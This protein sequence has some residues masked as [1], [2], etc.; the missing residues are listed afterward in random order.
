M[1]RLRRDDGFTLIE[2]LVSVSIG[3]VVLLGAFTL[4]DQAMPANNRIA[5]R[6]T[7]QARGRTAT[8]QVLAELHSVICVAQT[9][10]GVTTYQT[11]FDAVSN[12]TQVTFYTQMLGA[13]TGP[14]SPDPAIVNT[15]APEKRILHVTGGQLVEQRY[16]GVAG[17][18]PVGS[19]WT[20]PTL[21]SSRVVLPDVQAYDASTKYFTYYA[22]D[23][24]TL[25][26]PLSSADWPRVA[27]VQIAFKAG[28]NRTG[29]DPNAFAQLKDSA[30]VP[31]PVDYTDATTTAKGPQ[32]AY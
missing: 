2:L 6:V 7:A 20:W 8:E 24:S 16:A 14:T 3:T 18:S 22:A 5:D 15:F 17:G 23:G 10:A 27:R 21:T 1:S 9:N 19:T 25:T 29:S 13:K 32:C 26:T 30:A 28:P 31:L 12:D 4:V 11:P